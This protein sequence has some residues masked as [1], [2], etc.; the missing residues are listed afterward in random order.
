MKRNLPV[1]KN[2]KLTA[3]IMDLTYQGMGVAK[4]DG[5][6]LFCDDALPGEKVVLHVLKTGKNFGY[7]KVVERS[8]L[9][10]TIPSWVNC[11]GT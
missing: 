7:A 8:T 10:R 3:T 2:Q 9:S 11:R 6:S 1:T 4:V 5:Y